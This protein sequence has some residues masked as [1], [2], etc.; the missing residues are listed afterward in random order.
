MGRQAIKAYPWFGGKYTYLKYFLRMLGEHETYY[1]PFMGSAAVLL[2][3]VCA[4]QEYLSDGDAGLINLMKCIADAES[5]ERMIEIIVCTEYDKERFMESL[6]RI[7]EKETKEPDGKDAEWAADVYRSIVCSFNSL[8]KKYRSVKNIFPNCALWAVNERLQGVH[9]EKRDAIERLREVQDREDTVVLLDPP[10]LEELMGCKKVYGCGM[11][12]EKHREML[13][14]VRDMKARVI[15]CGYR[16]P[17][18][19]LYDECLS[20]GRNQGTE[21][22]WRCYHVADAKAPSGKKGDRRTLSEYV[23]MNYSPEKYDPSIK[24]VMT[25]EEYWDQ[26]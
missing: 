18:G 16:A 15:I 24:E 14:A 25:L 1:E 17:E 7:K 10:Y 13:E 8:R 3:K 22:R 9:I 4:G 20:K 2:N 19:N 21:R 5:L 11:E 12:V 26:P 23:W 6:M